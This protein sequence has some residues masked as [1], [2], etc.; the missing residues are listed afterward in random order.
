MTTETILW[1]SDV[2]GGITDHIQFL[3]I[4][5]ISALYIYLDWGNSL[6]AN[7]LMFDLL[8]NPLQNHTWQKTT[9]EKKIGK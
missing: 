9:K 8:T 5:Y 1:V 3:M 7:G 2:F 6:L 4:F